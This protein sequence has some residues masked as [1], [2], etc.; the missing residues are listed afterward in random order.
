MSHHHR[1]AGQSIQK[2]ARKSPPSSRGE[3]GGHQIY[4]HHLIQRNTKKPAKPAKPNTPSKQAP[5]P[6]SP[7]DVLAEAT[8]YYG[9]SNH[10]RLSTHSTISGGSGRI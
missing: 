2:E 7:K 3:W 4:A 8:A 5:R 10:S 1:A 9:S 6:I